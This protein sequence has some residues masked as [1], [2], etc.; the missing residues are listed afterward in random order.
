MQII[1][2]DWNP[3]TVENLYLPLLLLFQLDHQITKNNK[4]E[5]DPNFTLGLGKH[6][7]KVLRPCSFPKSGNMF[8][9]RHS[10]SVMTEGVNNQRGLFS[11]L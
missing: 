8:L 4:L 2:K 5:I 6:H 3:E 9:K 7:D 11:L 1:L 10:F